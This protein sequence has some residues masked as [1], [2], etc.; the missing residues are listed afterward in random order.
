MMLQSINLMDSSVE[1]PIL[2]EVFTEMS[3]DAQAIYD[4]YDLSRPR[5]FI[6]EVKRKGKEFVKNTIGKETALK[7]AGSLGVKLK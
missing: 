1:G 7:I 3:T 5:D 4:F 2:F 6:S